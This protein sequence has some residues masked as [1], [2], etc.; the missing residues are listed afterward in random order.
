[1]HP[2]L[3]QTYVRTALAD[4][5]DDAARWAIRRPGR[6]VVR[7]SI[8]AALVAAADGLQRAGRRVQ[9]PVPCPPACAEL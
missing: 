7:S 6:R 3:D 1:M 9:P 4:R 8:G 2:F 5:R